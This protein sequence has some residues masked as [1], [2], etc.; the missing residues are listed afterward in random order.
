MDFWR[1]FQLQTAGRRRAVKG[2]AEHEYPAQATGHEVVDCALSM[3]LP[4]LVLVKLPDSES[5]PDS[6]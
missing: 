5:Q 2:L 1:H 6:T 3:L 4:G